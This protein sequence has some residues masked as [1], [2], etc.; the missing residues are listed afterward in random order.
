MNESQCKT[1]P[2]QSVQNFIPFYCLSFSISTLI[3]PKRQETCRT[4][5]IYKLRDAYKEELA[6]AMGRPK[7]PSAAEQANLVR[8]LYQMDDYGQMLRIAMESMEGG[9][10][11][12]D[13]EEDE[14]DDDDVG[15]G[16]ARRGQ[17]GTRF[18]LLQS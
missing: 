3:I 4:E 9:E 16:A 17:K 10:D 13:H 8:S 11:G 2:V 15:G 1:E 14:D 5:T 6:A 12:D 18:E 7:P